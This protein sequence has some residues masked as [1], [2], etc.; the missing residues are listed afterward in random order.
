M[1]NPS[2]EI[3][4]EFANLAVRQGVNVQKGQL[5]VIN[6]PVEAYELIRECVKVGYEMGASKV[7]VL[8]DD[9]PITRMHYES[10]DLE[11]LCEIPD[12]Q[13]ERK[14]YEIDNKA[15]YLHIISDDPDLLVGIDE[16]KVNKSQMARIKAMAPYRYYT[17]NS[18]GQWSIIAYPSLNW[19][20]KVFP[21]KEDDEAMELLWQG[22]LKT[23]RVELNKSLD[24]WHKHNEEMSK[25]AQILNSLKLK[26]VHYK[27][28][29]G[30]DLY[31]GLPKGHI[32]AAAAETALGNGAI[33]NPNMPTE[34]VFSMPD[35]RDINGTVV[36]TMPLAH[37]GH[38]ISRFELTFKDG[39]IIDYKA[40]DNYET[41]KAIIDIDDGAKSLGEIALVPFDSPI[42]QTGILF[43]N[44]LFDENASCH[45]AIGA[46]YP[47]T[48]EGGIDMSDEERLK[49]G[50]N[51]SMTH[52]DFMVGSRDLSI[53]GT[54]ENGEEIV[55]F[56][57]GNFK[58]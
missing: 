6:G 50:S 20:K 4:K 45:F 14:K 35:C 22:I 55:I 27:N 26:K 52:V 1:F 31:V 41:L 19:A 29:A 57:N 36:S 24:N 39:K 25:H 2:K 43:Y 28:S 44:T 34:E 13:I 16:E 7:M 49:V 8:Y 11:K 38:V 53:I 12:W 51:V 46:S 56:E 9:D 32:W 58:I 47:G 17:M 5:F 33:F 21:G 54:K 18:V 23:T 15:C 3:I 10:M 40:D 37:D 48:I 30:T 42:N